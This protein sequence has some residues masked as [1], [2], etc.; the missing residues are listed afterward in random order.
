[1]QGVNPLTKEQLQQAFIYLLQ[2]LS[3]SY[4]FTSLVFIVHSYFISLQYCYT[5]HVSD[6]GFRR[7]VSCENIA[8][9]MAILSGQDMVE[10]DDVILI[11]ACGCVAWPQKNTSFSELSKFQN[12]GTCRKLLHWR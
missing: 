1:M 3:R 11:I 2:V 9:S 8:C 4:F 6:M 7:K 12:G 10:G 5:L